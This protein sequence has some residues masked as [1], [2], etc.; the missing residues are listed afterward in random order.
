MQTAIATYRYRAPED[1][2]RAPQPLKS[3]P[4]GD[5]LVV[6]FNRTNRKVS[7]IDLGTL[8]HARVDVGELR[9]PTPAPVAPTRI[10]RLLKRRVALFKKYQ[11]RFPHRAVRAVLKAL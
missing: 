9:F 7:L 10:R 2:A 6:A 4:P 8:R 3:F 11:F 1:P 5:R